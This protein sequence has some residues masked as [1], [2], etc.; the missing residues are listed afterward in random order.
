VACAQHLR[1]FFLS[2]Q[3]RAIPMSGKMP[4][5]HLQV[6]SGDKTFHVH[7]DGYNLMPAFK[8]PEGSQ[9][10]ASPGVHLLE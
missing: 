8:D 4:Q 3:P 2:A 5:G 1:Y 7:L 10:L 9:R 6:K